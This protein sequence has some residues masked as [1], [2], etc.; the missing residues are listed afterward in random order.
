[1]P[2]PRPLSDAALN[3]TDLVLYAATVFIFGSGWLPLKLQLG[4]VAPEVSG[5]WRFLAA[6]LVMF[7]ILLVFTFI[8]VRLAMRENRA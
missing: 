3:A 7:A 2:A 4:V 6:S 8:Y 5:V 1:M